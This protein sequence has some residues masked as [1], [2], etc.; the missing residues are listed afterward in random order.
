M[1]TKRKSWKTATPNRCAYLN[2]TTTDLQVVE[3][4]EERFSGQSLV[5][6]NRVRM[7]WGHLVVE[8]RCRTGVSH[9]VLP[10]N[11]QKNR[12]ASY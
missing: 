4:E 9:Q 5:E 7:M 3:N 8:W 11:R 10:T 2:A 6:L 1:P 12:L